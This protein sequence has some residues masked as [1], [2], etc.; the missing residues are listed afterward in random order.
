MGAWIFIL[1][2]LMTLIIAGVAFLVMNDYPSTAK[3]LTPA[4]RE[5]VTRRLVQD[6]NALADEYHMKYFWHA[7]KDWK[8]WVHMFITIGCYT[9][10][11]S[12]SLFLPTIVRTLGYT[13]ETAQLMTVPPYVVAC[14]CCITGGWLADRMQTRGVFMI[15]F[16]V[17][18][19]VGLI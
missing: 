18:A 6:R 3:F 1:E 2:G 10:L 14:I 13:N 7:V 8:I 5:E 15:G 11:Y 4:E 16:F 12:I 19:L 17:T 9:P